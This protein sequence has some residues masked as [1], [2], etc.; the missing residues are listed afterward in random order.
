[1]P[2]STKTVSLTL[3]NTRIATGTQTKTI[4]P[5]RTQTATCSHQPTMSFT[6]T[7]TITA[8]FTPTDNK[9]IAINDVLIYPNPYNPGKGD[10]K[11]SFNLTQES[12]II[13]V[14]IFTSG[15]RLIKY[16]EFQD[17]TYDAEKTNVIEIPKKHFN[18]MASGAYYMII[19]AKNS[20]GKETKSKPE[21]LIILK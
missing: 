5:T 19:F 21:V 8:G 17:K 14:R 3:T 16:M 7:G 15:L 20:E 6:A 13:K 4:T 10:L 1:Q 11:I 9:Q 2:T 18:E 12:K